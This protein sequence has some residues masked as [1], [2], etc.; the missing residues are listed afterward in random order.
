MGG[1]PKLMVYQGKAQQKMD[2]FGV[3]PII[4][5]YGNLWKP[6]YPR[7]FRIFSH[8]ET[9]LVDAWWIP[10]GCLVGPWWVPGGSLGPKGCR[11][12]AMT[13][14]WSCGSRRG[15]RAAACAWFRRTRRSLKGWRNLSC[16]SMIVLLMEEILP[17]TVVH[18]T[19]GSFNMFQ[20]S[21]WCRISQPSTV[22][23]QYRCCIAYY[24]NLLLM[25]F[26]D[27][28]KH[29]HTLFEFGRLGDWDNYPSRDV[30]DAFLIFF[31]LQVKVGYRH[32]GTDIYWKIGL[33]I[34]DVQS[35]SERLGCGPGSQFLDIGF[36]THL[37]DPAGGLPFFREVR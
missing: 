17:K 26:M 16:W 25:I 4:E 11:S 15:H 22:Q 29:L 1:I 13:P 36:L 5:T 23:R 37:A 14:S 21:F 28:K 18:P 6:A 20:P 34:D 33:A 32:K 12:S 27:M 3:P 24:S 10:G 8:F 19:I 7:I 9:S 35:A 2:D 31:A 30:D